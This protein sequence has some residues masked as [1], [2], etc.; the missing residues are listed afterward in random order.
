MGN[1]RGGGQGG[2]RASSGIAANPS[3]RVFE[4]Q[5][6]AMNPKVEYAVI[7]NAAGQVSNR[8][9]GTPARVPIP[10]PPGPLRGWSVTHLHPGAEGAVSLSAMDVKIAMDRGVSIRAFG[11]DGHWMELTN[12]SPYNSSNFSARW[13][14]EYRALQ[15][16]WRAGNTGGR[17]WTQAYRDTMVQAVHGGGQYTRPIEGITLTWG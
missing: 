14:S 5:I 15:R 10:L 2:K 3:V 6:A 13:R 4:A 8:I 7:V 11:P 12:N 16:D 1:G 17:S 9:K